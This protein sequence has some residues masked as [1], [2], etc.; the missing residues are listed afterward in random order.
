M[1]DVMNA[2][3]D[4]VH[5]SEWIDAG[6]ERDEA[7]LWNRVAKVA[8]ES[9]E[10]IQALIGLTGRNPRKGVCATKDDLREELLDV[11]LTALAA[12]EHIDDHPG[13]SF[14]LLVDKTKRVAERAGVSE[15]SLRN[16]LDAQRRAM[17]S[18]PRYPNCCYLCGWNI[19]SHAI[20]QYGLDCPGGTS[21][22]AAAGHLAVRR[23]SQ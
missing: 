21:P 11:A 8:E 12:I 10:T 22:A 14:D 13:N 20:S 16:R 4:L 23:A 9:G 3:A 19:S 15:F 5:L 6:R 2:Q 18:D 7:Q 17:W 1:Y